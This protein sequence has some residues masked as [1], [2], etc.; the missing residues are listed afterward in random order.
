MKS[1][2]I[3]EPNKTPYGGRIKYVSKWSVINGFT[4]F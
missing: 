3:F 2:V 1:K 4:K